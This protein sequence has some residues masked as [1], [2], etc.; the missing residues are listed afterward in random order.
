MAGK[1][2]PH[3][4]SYKRLFSH[5]EMVVQLLQT[6]VAEDWV[7]QLDFD[8]LQKVDSSFVTKEFREREDD[9]IW[10]VKFQDKWLYL[11]ILLEFQSTVDPIMAVRVMGYIALL[12]QERA[13]GL[14]I[15]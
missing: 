7:T 9:V 11:Y 4:H 10:R 8:S 15:K 3:D 5:A 12:Y 14:R 1:D 6:F 2:T 13:V